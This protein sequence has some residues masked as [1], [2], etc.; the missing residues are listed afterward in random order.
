MLLK[1]KIFTVSEVTARVKDLLE[2][3]LPVMWVEGEI[4]NFHLH[5][6]GHM[7]FTLKDTASQLRAVMF[8]LKNVRLTFTPEDGMKVLAFG[9]MNVYEP[10]GEYQLN[11]ERLRPSGLGALALALEQLKKKLGAEGL[12]APEHKKPLPRF[13]G[14]VAL[15]TSPTGAAIRDM[16]RALTS[17]FPPVEIVVVPTA[18]QGVGAAGQVAEAIRLVDR[19]GLADVVIV[20]RGGG[21][22]ED[23][24][25]FNEEAVARAMFECATP[26]VSAVGHEVDFTL[27]DA[28]ADERAATPSSAAGLVVPDR[29]ELLGVIALTTRGFESE[30]RSFIARLAER[31]ATCR[32]AYA[33]RLPREMVE[34][35][36]Q[37]VD[38]IE[39]RLATLTTVKVD[40]ARGRL[41]RFAAELKAF[42]PRE[43]LSRGFAAVG[44]LPGLTTVTSV[45]DVSRGSEVRVTVSD[46]SF[47]CAVTSVSEPSG[48]KT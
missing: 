48:R 45:S 39:R 32:E 34:R 29:G 28:V 36:A 23:L 42:D 13:P 2:S 41:E 44:L 3:S 14:V 12:F 1:E 22:L 21:S 35:L 30:V 4:S 10:R 25:A 5:S 15:V 20:G 6:S 18:V 11:I 24:W 37:R 47:D 33:F 46:G 27:A 38:E 43:V 7:Y 8:R 40:A 26:V 17:R 31:I 16:I 9:R 19:W